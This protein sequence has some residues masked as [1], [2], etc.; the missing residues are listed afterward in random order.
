MEKTEGRISEFE[1]RSIE[2]IQ[3]KEEKKRL[4][5]LHGTTVKD[6]TSV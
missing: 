1:D 5:K 6:L 3:Q 4:T 2:S